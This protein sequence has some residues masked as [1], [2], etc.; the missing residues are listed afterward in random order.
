[1]QGGGADVFSAAFI[2]SA[3]SSVYLLANNSSYSAIT[4]KAEFSDML[5]S[6]AKYF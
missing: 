2:Y 6:L 3:S 5:D 1:M 4:S